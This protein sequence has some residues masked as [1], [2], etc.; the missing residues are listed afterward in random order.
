M[1]YILDYKHNVTLC[2]YSILAFIIQTERT[3]VGFCLM[4]KKH[5]SFVHFWNGRYCSKVLRHQPDQL[6]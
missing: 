4:F 2:L 1:S 5:E 3:L 6:L